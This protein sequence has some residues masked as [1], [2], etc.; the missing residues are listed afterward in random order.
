MATPPPPPPGSAGNSGG[1]PTTPAVP[2]PAPGKLYDPQGNDIS[3]AQPKP[4][5]VKEVQSLKPSVDPGG[6]VS[7][8][9]VDPGHVWYT[10]YLIRN[11]QS[12]FHKA[13]KYLLDALEGHK[14][15]CGIG[16]GPSEFVQQYNA[17][18]ALYLEVWAKAVVAVG[19]VSTGLTITANN[20]VSAEYASHPSWGAPT[21]LKAVPEVIRT[22]PP[23]G[24]VADLGW[25]GGDG[26][27]A[28]GDR[29]I[30]NV[31]GEVG[32]ALHWLLEQALRRALRHG[33]VADITPG[34]NDD[35]LPKVAALWRK[36]AE[37]AEKSGRDLDAAIGYLRDPGPSP[38][39]G[40]WQAAMGQ[41]TGSLWGTR[42]WGKNAPSPVSQ[43]YR[44][45]HM[46]GQQPV[47][48]ILIDTAR[49]IA[50]LLDR[51]ADAVRAVRKV[52]E[53]VY[54]QA[55]KDCM[56]LDNFK[57]A[58][59]DIFR[60]VIGNVV[61]LAEQFIE[62]ID[63]P[64]LDSGVNRYN[65][66]TQVLAQQMKGLTDALEEARKSVPTFL[67]EEARAQSI[68]ARSIEG[69]EPK[70]NWTVPGDSASNHTYPIDLANQEDMKVGTQ[71]T[72]PIDRHVA[73]NPEQLQQRMRDQHPPAA[74]SFTDLTSAQRFVQSTIDRNEAEITQKLTANPTGQFVLPKTPFTD[75]T[76]STVTSATGLPADTHN[77]IVRI[78]GVD[79]GRVPPFIVVTAFPESP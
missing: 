76:G 9:D 31:M 70:H 72:H 73:L 43:G 25:G 50:D 64:K 1:P 40:E 10:S 63:T 12:D 6:Y 65:A 51:F 75:V 15:V 8:F 36:V 33:K 59:E 26:G 13:P 19:G 44:W 38:V 61:G 56:E 48:Q 37:D 29:I 62:N 78:Q 69:Y 41:F 60:L 71:T 57:G 22:P 30:D 4:D 74:S 52:I 46:S 7:G 77:V 20:Y 28:W 2:S 16:S 11:H 53:Q 21:T 5:P 27:G 14:H 34:G 3:Q 24:K 66:D 35:D 79:D 45:K 18:T 23:Y 42:P 54:I 58:A 55:A 47:L 32:R 68:G 17:V 67:A 39:S 49:K